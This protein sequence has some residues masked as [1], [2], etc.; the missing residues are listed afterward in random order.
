MDGAGGGEPWCYNGTASQAGS[1]RRAV[2]TTGLRELV[3]AVVRPLSALKRVPYPWVVVGVCTVTAMSAQF[4]LTGI[5]VM[6]PFIQEDLGTSL[7]QLGLIMSMILIGATVPGLL[8]GWMADVIG[9]RRLQTITRIGVAAS[10]MAFSR[11]T[12]LPQGLVLGVVV[13]AANG[14]S[15][16]NVTKAISEWVPPRTRGLAMG[17]EQSSI[18][19]SGIVVAVLLTRLALDYDWRTSLLVAGAVVAVA[20]VFFFAFYRDKPASE[21]SREAQPRS[22]GRIGLVIRDRGIWFACLFAAAFQGFQPVVTSFLIIFLRDDLGMSP[23]A[24]S[25][26]LGVSMAGGTVGRIAWGLASDV[27]R[28]GRVVTLLMVSVTSGLAMLVLIWMPPDTPL[29]LVLVIVFLMGATCLASPGLFA[30]LV[31]EQAGPGLTGTAMGFAITI[32]N[33]GGF[34][35]APVF[36]YIVDETGSYDNGWLMMVGLAV[37]ATA[38]LLPLL[39]GALSKRGGSPLGAGGQGDSGTVARR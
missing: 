23:E 30:V 19:L 21:D 31:A 24:S 35:V 15:Y 13:G 20:T 39:P 27:M 16:A 22:G 26:V 9:V 25:A 34:A 3:D 1:G 4:S 5:G 38:F 37:V 10:T 17:I 29:G 33:L 36:G 18:P 11:I 12:S 7:S 6:F 2:S 14:P 8:A 32:T 28:G